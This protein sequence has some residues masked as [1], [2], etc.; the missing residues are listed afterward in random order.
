MTTATTMERS[1]TQAAAAAYRD[2][3]P[4][5]AAKVAETKSETKPE[6]KPVL[7][8]L[9]NLEVAGVAGSKLVYGPAHRRCLMNR[10]SGP[11]WWVPGTRR[12]VMPV[13]PLPLTPRVLAGAWGA[14]GWPWGGSKA[15][16]CLVVQ[17]RLG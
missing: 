7:M 12:S 9:P 10:A 2:A 1:G 5:T 13:S 4:D 15:A 6:T 11:M 14:V 8:Q 16:R 3:E 17:M